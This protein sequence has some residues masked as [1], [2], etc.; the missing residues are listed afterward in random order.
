[1]YKFNTMKFTYVMLLFT[2][3]SYTQNE[4]RAILL[5]KEDKQPIEFVNIYNSKDFTTSNKGWKFFIYIKFRF[6]LFL[7]RRIQ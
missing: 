3:L 4:K 6:Y 1:M 5:D 2:M 7:Y